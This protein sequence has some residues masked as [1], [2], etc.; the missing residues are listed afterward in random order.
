MNIPDTAAEIS[1][2]CGSKV[3]YFRNLKY[4]DELWD[5]VC[6]LGLVCD[7]E[8]IYWLEE[9]YDVRVGLYEVY[10]LR[11][12]HSHDILKGKP[13]KK[14]KDRKFG[15][16]EARVSLI[17]RW[18]K[19]CMRHYPK[20]MP[21]KKGFVGRSIHNFGKRWPSCHPFPCSQKEEACKIFSLTTYPFFRLLLSLLDLRR[22]F[23]IKHGLCPL[24]TK[25][26]A[27]RDAWGNTGFGYV[28][29]TTFHIISTFYRLL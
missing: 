11:I 8:C 4:R 1:G 19:R 17:Q 27:N 26:T 16:R 5:W 14:Q 13:L 29:L 2:P 3:G 28:K 15:I 23:T 10:D 21:T 9:Y 20:N 22:V 25:G 24:K 12:I 6:S 7:G 18:S